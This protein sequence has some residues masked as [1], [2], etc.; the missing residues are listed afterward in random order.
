MPYDKELLLSFLWVHALHPHTVHPVEQ[1]I[2]EQRANPLYLLLAGVL[3]SLESISPTAL[4]G[5]T[6]KTGSPDADF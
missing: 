5:N 3:L 2:P 1:N 4:L 6:C